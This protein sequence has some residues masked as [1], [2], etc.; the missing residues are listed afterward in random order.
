LHCLDAKTGKTIWRF[1]YGRN[2]F[3]SPVWADDK[4][5]IGA[6]N[7]TFDILKDA[8]NKCE[9]LY[10]QYFPGVPEVEINGSPAVANGRI[11]FLTST[12]FY[13]IGK[14]NHQAAAA[15]LPQALEPEPAPDAKPAQLLVFPAEV[16]LEPGQSAEFRARLYDAQGHFLREVQPDWSLAAAPPP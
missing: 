10:Q 3:G 5:Y 12:D 4:I 15:A 6:V 8:G 13:C 14:K 7:S 16:T 11:Y 2:S 9:R 1:A